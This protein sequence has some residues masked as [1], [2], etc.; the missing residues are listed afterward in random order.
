[1]S[2]MRLP[3]VDGKR[4]SSWRLADIPRLYQSGWIQL[5]ALTQGRGEVDK[6]GHRTDDSW[7]L[8]HRTA[9]SA[10]RPHRRNQRPATCGVPPSGD[11]RGVAVP[12][13]DHGKRQGEVNVFAIL[14]ARS[15]GKTLRAA[16]DGLIVK[17][18]DQDEVRAAYETYS[19][20][21]IEN[22]SRLPDACQGVEG[23]V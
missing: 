9:I 20:G 10:W 8:P 16:T 12:K 17:T 13:G 23:E 14:V 15:R 5:I 1:L 19:R 21:S 11:G 22:R 18:G 3:P 6:P 7:L 4:T 2:P